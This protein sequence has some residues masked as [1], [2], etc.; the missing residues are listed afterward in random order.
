M[1]IRDDV[2][3]VTKNLEQIKWLNSQ[4]IYGKVKEYITAK[5]ATGKHI[6]GVV[7]YVIA[8]Q[9]IDVTVIDCKA[10]GKIKSK[11][12]SSEQLES[13]GAKLRTYKVIPA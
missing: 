11:D 12:M 7:P 10:I 6:V 13:Q 2:I 8:A 9:A 1:K 3:I 4:G 5:E